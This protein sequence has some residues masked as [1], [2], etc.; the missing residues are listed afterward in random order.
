MIHADVVVTSAR[1]GRQTTVGRLEITNVAGSRR[2]GTYRAVFSYGAD[3][4]R[5]PAGRGGG[6]IPPDH[7]VRVGTP[8]AG[9]QRGRRAGRTDTMNQVWFTSDTHFGHEA[10]LRLSGDFPE[11]CAPMGELNLWQAV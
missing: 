6:A 2:H 9:P 5:G 3:S 4:A 10:V 7:P 8:A 1:D 11:P